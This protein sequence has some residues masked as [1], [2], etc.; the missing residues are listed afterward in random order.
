MIVAIS[1]NLRWRWKTAAAL[2]QIKYRH[3]ALTV[4]DPVFSSDPFLC[5]DRFRLRGGTERIS[6]SLRVRG[7]VYQPKFADLSARGCGVELISY[8]LQ[9]SHLLNRMKAVALADVIALALFS[10]DRP[11]LG[12]M[13]PSS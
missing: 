10:N 13:V 9:K 2:M 3:D 8:R 1:G 6:N 11:R 4:A 5:A 7:N 12:P